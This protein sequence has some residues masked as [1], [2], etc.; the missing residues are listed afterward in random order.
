MPIKLWVK[1]MTPLKIFDGTAREAAKGFP[2]NVNVGAALGLA[3]IGPDR[4][5]VEIWADPTVKYNTHKVTVEAEASN[6]TMTI[7]NV[8]SEENPATGKITALSALAML[9][10]LTAPLVVGT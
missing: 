1:Y 2:A 5:T 10:R 8:P 7:Q 6:F 4:T 3:G 9:Q